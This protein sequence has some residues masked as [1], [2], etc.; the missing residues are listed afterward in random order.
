MSLSF[1][2][3]E[4]AAFKAARGAGFSW[5]LSE[6][7]GFAARWL[8]E[9][10]FDW[11]PALLAACEARQAE[12]DRDV[13]IAGNGRVSPGAGAD[14][15]CPIHIGA[16]IADC[17]DLA[18]GLH[19]ALVRAPLLLLPFLDLLSARGGAIAV[20]LRLQAQ[21]PAASVR[22][23]RGE[24]W[25]DPQPLPASLASSIASVDIAKSA[26]ALEKGNVARLA[27]PAPIEPALGER[28]KAFEV[29]TYVPA[30]DR[31]RVA[32]AG[33]GLTDND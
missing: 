20:S 30:S 25:G 27:R 3:I 14:S 16:W 26:T 1:N 17:G 29:R 12:G 8:A 31:S 7:A 24:V 22:V 10:G 32:G 4:G 5:G 11:L 15:V 18:T 28:L 6:E 33:A 21:G 13:V 9:R 2:E 19:I 23:C